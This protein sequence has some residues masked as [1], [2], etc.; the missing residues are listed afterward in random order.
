MERDVPVRSFFGRI[1]LAY[2]LGLLHPIFH[3]ELHLVKDVRNEF[4]HGTIGI[5]FE[6]QTVAALVS[7][8]VIPKAI[9][10][11]I[12]EKTKDQPELNALLHQNL[13]ERFISS[14]AILLHQL[15]AV[16]ERVKQVAISTG[17]IH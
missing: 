9:D 4:A 5:S 7:K 13:R 11:F 10:K 17:R 12:F 1:E 15:S 6:S 14:G 2:R 16:H 3:H 8:L